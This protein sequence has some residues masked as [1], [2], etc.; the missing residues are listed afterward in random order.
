MKA[1][2]RV[3]KIHIELQ[4]ENRVGSM[5]PHEYDIYEAQSEKKSD[6]SLRF[7]VFTKIKPR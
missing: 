5:M 3:E 4:Y 2:A 7:V 1:A 6:N